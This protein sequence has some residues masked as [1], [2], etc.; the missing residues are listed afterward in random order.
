[1]PLVGQTIHS[2]R[3]EALKHSFGGERHHDPLSIS[4]KNVR[5]ERSQQLF[6]NTAKMLTSVLLVAVL[7]IT[8]TH[9]S[10]IPRS[11]SV[12]SI[13]CAGSSYTYTS[14][15]GYGVI[16]GDARDKFKDTLG[17]IGSSIAF[18]RDSWKKRGSTYEGVLWALPDRGWNA[19]GTLNYQDRVHQFRVTFEP[20]EKASLEQPGKPNL[21]LKYI[22]SVAFNA[23]DGT[24]VTGLDADASGALVYEGFPDLPPATYTGDGFG[25]P[26]AG[27]KRISLDCEGLVLG[28]DGSFWISEE[29]GPYVYKFNSRG[30]MVSAIRPPDAFIP[31]RNGTQRQVPLLQS[32]YSLG[33]S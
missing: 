5:Y 4:K 15:A 25:G 12:N 10:P 23:P 31:L 29:Y 16:T 28:K 3:G 11:A 30:K 7:A 13:T 26:G 17:G 27:G 9:A 2:I 6:L 24:P 20:N 21:E 33:H 14:L 1:M 19:D 8:G 22:D 32:T 18:Q